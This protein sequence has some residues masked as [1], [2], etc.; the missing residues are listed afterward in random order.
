[1][2]RSIFTLILAITVAGCATNK[3]FTA[4]AD[5][6]LKKAVGQ[7]TYLAT[8]VEPGAYPKTYHAKDNKLETSDSGWW[9]SG[10][11]PGTLLFLD[12]AQ[13]APEL[14][15]E[16]LSFLQ[17]LKKEQFNTTTHDLGFMMYC[18]FGTAERLS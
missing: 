13:N 9:C 6:A 12:E 14:K 15:K 8:Q 3:K 7:Y 4:K 11:Y 1:M 16:A 5:E 10:F 17:D 18:S 2:T